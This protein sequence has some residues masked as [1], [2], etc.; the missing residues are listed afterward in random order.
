MVSD[1]RLFWV[2]LA[3]NPQR[4]GHSDIEFSTQDNL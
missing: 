2:M 4:N 1:W 3:E